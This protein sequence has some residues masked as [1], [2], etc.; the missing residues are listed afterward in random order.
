MKLELSAQE[1]ALIVQRGS[2]YQ[3]TGGNWVYVLDPATNVA[4]KRNIRVGRQNPNYYEILDGLS[5]GEII[6][7]SSYENYGDKDELIL[8]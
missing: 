6:I 7:T 4:R 2:F 3:T 8:K 1:E 5:P